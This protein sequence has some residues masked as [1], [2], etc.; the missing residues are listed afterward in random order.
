MVLGLSDY[1]CCVF[2]SGVLF[3]LLCCLLIIVCC[4][5]VGCFWCWLLCLNG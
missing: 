4:G 2:G 1:G 3:F 5:F